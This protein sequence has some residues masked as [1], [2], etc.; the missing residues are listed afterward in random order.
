MKK[1]KKCNK[2]IPQ[3]IIIDNKSHQLHT[4][5]F[6]LECSPFGKHNNRDLT[7]PK[8]SIEK[9]KLRK[10][11]WQ[12]EFQI[13]KRRSHQRKINKIKRNSRCKICGWHKHPE[14]LTFHHKNKKLKKATISRIIS[15]SS[16][17]NRIKEEIDKCILLC[18]TCHAWKHYKD[19]KWFKKVAENWWASV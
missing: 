11:G 7:K 19:K 2:Q 9:I 16:N 12:K 17:W 18:P 3:D 13:K 14:I 15:S 5:S 10:K 8:I 1:C 4:R 6:C